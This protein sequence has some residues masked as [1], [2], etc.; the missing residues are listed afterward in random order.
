MTVMY[1]FPGIK[2]DRTIWFM[3]DTLC[4]WSIKASAFSGI[5]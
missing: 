3:I 1:L 4:C 2:S 5:G